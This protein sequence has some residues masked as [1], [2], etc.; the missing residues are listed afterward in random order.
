MRP[1]YN[2]AFSLAAAFLFGC[3]SDHTLPTASPASPTVLTGAYTAIV[4]PSPRDCGFAS[5]I[6]ASGAAAGTTCAFSGGV[7]KNV[8][9]AWSATAHAVTLLPS[10]PFPTTITGIS[11]NGTIVGYDSWFQFEVSEAL[12]WKNGSVHAVDKGSQG[13]LSS[14]ESTIAHFICATDCTIVGSFRAEPR[15]LSPP[16]LKAA[17]WTTGGFRADVSAPT[18]AFGA[19]FV[20]IGGGFIFGNIFDDNGSPEPARWGAR[21]WELRP[22]SDC[23]VSV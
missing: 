23:S 8:P 21:G 15:S 5:V 16:E 9:L 4:L 19:E 12:E 2:F 13:P 17:I 1:T 20:A 3:D 11:D 6:N 10:N 22:H 14:N 7:G 18:G